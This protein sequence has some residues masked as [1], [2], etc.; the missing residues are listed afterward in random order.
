LHGPFEAVEE[1]VTF[2]YFASVPVYI[3]PD[4]STYIYREDGKQI[5][6][7]Q[8]EFIEKFKGENFIS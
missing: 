2:K 3:L 7:G 4:G 8:L 5:E 1:A 6:A